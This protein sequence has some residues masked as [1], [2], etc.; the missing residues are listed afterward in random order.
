MSEFFNILVT[1]S[2][3][4]VA[5]VLI[6]GLINMLKK[7]NANRSQKLMRLRV[8]AQFIAIIFIMIFFY[9]TY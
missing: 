7:G 3:L 4:A 2:V 5:F 8:V 9:F 1:I 6:L